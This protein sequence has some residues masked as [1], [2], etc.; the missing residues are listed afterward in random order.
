[1]LIVY[2]EIECKKSKMVILPSGN[3]HIENNSIEDP[4]WMHEIFQGTLTN[5]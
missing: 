4:M 3:I 5:V 1:M 2:K